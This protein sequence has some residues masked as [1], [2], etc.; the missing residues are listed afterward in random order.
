VST[1]SNLIGNFRERVDGEREREEFEIVVFPH[2]CRP[3]RNKGAE[4]R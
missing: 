2:Q 4:S 1:M 3:E